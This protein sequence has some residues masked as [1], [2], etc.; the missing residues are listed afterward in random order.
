M[1]IQY[2]PFTDNFDIVNKGIQNFGDYL[3]GLG[4][5]KN[6]IKI[7]PNNDLTFSLKAGKVLLYNSER[8]AVETIEVDAVSTVVFDIIDIQGNVLLGG[9][10]GVD[11]SQIN[12]NQSAEVTSLS[13]A[14]RSSF[15]ELFINPKTQALK[16]LIGQQEYNNIN[17]AREQYLLENKVL[18]SVLESHVRLGGFLGRGNT[19]SLLAATTSLVLS[20]KFG[21]LVGLTED[22]TSGASILPITITG[23]EIGTSQGQ[24]T[25]SDFYI[26][27]TGNVVEVF[28]R[29]TSYI[30]DNPVTIT[31]PNGTFSEVL[32]AMVG[33]NQAGVSSEIGI[34]IENEEQFTINRSNNIDG[35]SPFSIVIK[36]LA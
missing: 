24:V 26:Q 15:V 22:N 18:P 32:M 13:R 25:P 21:S 29:F 8:K 36:G 6:G 16:L 34:V 7:I 23:A 1:G 2:N 30:Q 4:A 9:V 35:N 10:T 27:K 33:R 11:F 3:N 31:V 12:A 14:T 5:I 20:D 17:T 19:T 28:G